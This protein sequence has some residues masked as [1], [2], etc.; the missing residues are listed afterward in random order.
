V[1]GT[2]GEVRESYRTPDLVADIKRRRLELLGRVIIMDQARVA[3][4][5]FESK[6]EKGRRKVGRPRSRWLEDTEND[7]RELKLKMWR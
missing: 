4:K 2:K 3:K 7:L 1:W 5:T 6:P